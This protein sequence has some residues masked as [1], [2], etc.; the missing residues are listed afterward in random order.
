MDEELIKELQ[1]LYA[2]AVEGCYTVKEVK[3]EL[4]KLGITPDNNTPIMDQIRK[5]VARGLK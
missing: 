5:L 3:D 2:R 4:Q 1:R